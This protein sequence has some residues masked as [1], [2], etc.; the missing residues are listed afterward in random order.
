LQT[1]AKYGKHLA[2]Q[3][4]QGSVGPGEDLPPYL[5]SSVTR[6]IKTDMLVELESLK[7]SSLSRASAPKKCSISSLRESSFKDSSIV[8]E[9]GRNSSL[10]GYPLSSRG[11]SPLP[12]KPES[13]RIS[14]L[15]PT[16]P[17]A[18]VHD[19]P[20]SKTV[21]LQGAVPVPSQEFYPTQNIPKLFHD[22]P[23]Q[24]LQF[25]Q[26][27]YARPTNEQQIFG[28]RPIPGGERLEES[29]RYDVYQDH[30]TPGTSSLP[31]TFSRPDQLYYQQSGSRKYE[32]AVQ[33]DEE[34]LIACAFCLCGIK[35]DDMNQHLDSNCRLHIARLNSS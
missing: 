34:E 1:I 35:A 12:P 5:G 16:T 2:E 18:F 33:N 19:P 3:I 11:N 17:G 30:Y 31:S 32:Y 29:R 4:P 21:Y 23:T 24:A 14:T 22:Q 15:L 28:A 8:I 6:Q 7:N 20:P 13:P 27:Q 25:T 10:S 26:P 9:N